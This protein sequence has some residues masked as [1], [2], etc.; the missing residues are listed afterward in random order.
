MC[1]R[2]TPC[3]QRSCSTMRSEGRLDVLI[4]NCAIQPPASCVPIHTLADDHWHRLIAVN[5]T[6]IFLASKAVSAAV[7]P[8]ALHAATPATLLYLH[9]DLLPAMET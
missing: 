9:R 8:L 7:V 5:L 6:S 4:N 1:T 2:V 3:I